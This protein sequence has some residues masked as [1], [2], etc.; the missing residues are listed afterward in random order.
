MYTAS[1]P[2]PPAQFENGTKNSLSKMKFKNTSVQLSKLQSSMV[3]NDR[4]AAHNF[5]I[6]KII[7][8]NKTIEVRV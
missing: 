6:D 8:Q 5:E 3:K 4:R 2:P 7:Q 1:K